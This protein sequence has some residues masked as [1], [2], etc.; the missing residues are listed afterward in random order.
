MTRLGGA[1]LPA[2]GNDPPVRGGTAR[3]RRARRAARPPR[4]L[5]RRLR[6]DRRRRVARPGPAAL[7]PAGRTGTREPPRRD[8]MGGGDRR[9]GPCR[10]VPV[11]GDGRT[12]PAG[13]ACC[14]ATPKRCSSCR[15]S[16]RSSATRSCSRPPARPPSSTAGTTEPNSSASK[17]STRRVSPTTSSR[18]MAFLA[19]GNARYGLGDMSRRDRA[20]GAGVERFRR[21]A[22]PYHARV[23]SHVLASFRSV[24]ETPPPGRR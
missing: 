7:A 10:T 5:L 11:F 3:R 12:E 6:G 9:R 18:A 20:P 24:A 2:V 1:S 21:F 8:G 14:C 16:T 17:H 22:D 19:R 15:A 13:R 23:L 4:R